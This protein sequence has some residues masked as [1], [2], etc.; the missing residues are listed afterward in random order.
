VIDI[1]DKFVRI[2]S[3]E[4][5]K[6][7]DSVSGS[8]SDAAQTRTLIAH[9]LHFIS[10]NGVNCIV[11]WPCGD[12]NYQMPLVESVHSYIGVDIVP[13]IIENNKRKLSAYSNLSFSVGDIAKD[14]I[15]QCDLLI[16]RDCFVHLPY[17]LVVAAISNILSYEVKFVAITTFMSRGGEP[18]KDVDNWM[19]NDYWRPMNIMREP[20]DLPFPFDI[21]V[22]NCTEANGIYKDKCLGIWKVDDLRNHLFNKKQYLSI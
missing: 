9:L 10:Y 13:A 22:E 11:D 17:S 7:G 1:K 20:Y 3:S 2:H 5:W 4:H 12:M 21:I 14:P 19:C 15:P 8:G 18:A 6:S 16:V